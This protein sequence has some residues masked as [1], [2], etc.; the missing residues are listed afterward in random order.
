MSALNPD[1]PAT[2]RTRDEVAAL[3]DGLDLVPPGV[4]QISTWR[5]DSDGAA[6]WGGLA[7]E[8]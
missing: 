5:A 4:V 2:L 7:R 1:Y 8:P 6:F 3:F